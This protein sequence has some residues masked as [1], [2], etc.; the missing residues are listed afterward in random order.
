M[1]KDSCIDGW[2]IDVWIDGGWMVDGWTD[3]DGWMD[4]WMT[5]DYFCFFS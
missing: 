4:G 3:D 2:W 1:L 5:K